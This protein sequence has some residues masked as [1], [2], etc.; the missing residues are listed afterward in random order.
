MEVQPTGGLMV[1]LDVARF[2]DDKTV[3]S[4]RRG[5]VLLKQT[6]W[7]KHDLV[8][9]AARARNEIVAY[10]IRPEQIAVDTIGIGAGVADMMRAWWPDKVDH[11]TGRIT[12]TIADINSSL[13]LDDGQNYNLRALMATNVRAWLVGASIPNDPDLMTDLTALRYSYR[14]GELLIESKDDAKRRGIKSPDRFD[15]L[16]LTFAIPPAPL[17][18][19]RLPVVPPYQSHAPGSGM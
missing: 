15:S 9:T 19:D 6:V 13:R 14:A 3:L 1:G 2:G 7:A 8:Q 16:A 5:R 10:N 17:V 11:K 18:E 12:K 4:L